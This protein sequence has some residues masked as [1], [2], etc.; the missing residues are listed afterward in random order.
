[1]KFRR[2]KTIKDENDT[3]LCCLRLAFTILVSIVINELDVD[4]FC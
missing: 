1:M 2:Y 4:D 3:S